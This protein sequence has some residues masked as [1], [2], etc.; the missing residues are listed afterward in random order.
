MLVSY[1]VQRKREGLLPKNMTIQ[2]YWDQHD[3]NIFIFDLREVWTWEEFHTAADTAME[4]IKNVAQP[5]YVISLAAT[6]FPP[7]DSIISHFQRI[8][9]QFP[10]NLILIVVV[11]DNFL[12]ETVNQIFFKISASGRRIGRIAKSLDA[13]RQLILDYHAKHHPSA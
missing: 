3:P 2:Y 8:T 1:L 6:G 7:S 5:V 11:T 12:V 4:S 9:Q 13:A 10:P